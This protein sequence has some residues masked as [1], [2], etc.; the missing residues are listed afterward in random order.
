MSKLEKLVDQLSANVDQADLVNKKISAASIGWHIVHI[1]L[2][3][4]QIVITI[5]QSNPKLYKK[6]FNF[7]RS[8]VF[9]INYFP[10]GKVKAPKIVLPGEELTKEAILEHIVSTQKALAFLKGCEKNKY[11]MHPIFGSLNTQQTLQ[12][13]NVHTYHHFKIIRDIQEIN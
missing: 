7:T 13:F 6:Q 11:F 5:E 10:R 3:I 8:L 1:C 12:F 2:V 9:L 4:K